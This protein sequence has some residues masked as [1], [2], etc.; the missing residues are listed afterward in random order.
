M[1]FCSVAESKLRDAGFIEFAEAASHHAVVLLLGGLRE[2]ENETRPAAKIQSDTVNLLDR[3]AWLGP[4]LRG[5]VLDE[6]AKV[7]GLAKAHSNADEFLAGL[8]GAAA[9][10]RTTFGVPARTG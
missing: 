8:N 5:E 6:L 7:V 3:A 4:D 9:V 1:G 2:W 10:V